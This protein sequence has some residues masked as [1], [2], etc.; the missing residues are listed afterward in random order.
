[1]DEKNSL[2]FISWKKSFRP[3]FGSE[4]DLVSNRNEYQE[5]PWG[6]GDK[7]SR[8]VG[9][10]TLLHIPNVLKSGSLNFLESYG[11]GQACNGIVLCT[12]K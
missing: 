8:C 11:L 7:D 5:F 12:L 2:P 3:H 4:F 6:V 10:I 1:M 9:L